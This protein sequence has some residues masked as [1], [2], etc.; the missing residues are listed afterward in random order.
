MVPVAFHR[1]ADHHLQH[2][3]QP[4]AVQVSNHVIVSLYITQ[5]LLLLMKM[6]MYTTAKRDEID[7]VAYGS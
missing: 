7:T 3:L 2:D 4:G 5:Q 1:L 6:L